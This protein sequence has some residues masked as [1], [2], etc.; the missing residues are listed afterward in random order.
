[1]HRGHEHDAMSRE[2]ARKHYGLFALNMIG[3]FVIMYL[4]MFSM[5]AGL[6]DFFN[7]LN[8]AYMALTMAAPMGM[9]MLLTMPGMYPDRRLNLIIHA[10]L[11][12]VF[13]ASLAAVRQQSLIGDR[14]FLRSMI[15]HHSGAILMCEEAKLSDPEIRQLCLGIVKSQA[16]E[17]V[18]MKA[19]LER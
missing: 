9:L 14:Q 19:I 1:M 13:V 10:A 6:G 17:I 16:D 11:A 12:L 2:M 18:K 15:P 4:M 3:G 7:N 8:M 5:I